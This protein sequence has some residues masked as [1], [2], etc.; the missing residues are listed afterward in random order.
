M[1]VRP[2]PPSAV[3]TPR[4]VPS[5]PAVRATRG[6]RGFTLIEILLAMMVFL[7][8]VTGIY[9]LLSTALGMQREGLDLSRAT[10]SAE[11]VV[12]QL[13]QEISRGQHFDASAG[14]WTDVTAATL[15]DG[16]WYAVEFVPET[17]N[18]AEGTLLVNVRLARRE[19]DLAGARPVSWVLTPGPTFADAVRAAQ[20]RQAPP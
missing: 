10:R 5:L 16:T 1:N 6:R 17:G 18:E 11:G 14:T 7:A 20:A 4:A 3:S 12:H 9:A 13:E 15:P 2:Q 8:G 19:R